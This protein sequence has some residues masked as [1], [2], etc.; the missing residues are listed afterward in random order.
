[1]SAPLP[2]IRKII[3]VDMDA[4]FAS[5]EQRDFPELQG[6]PVA[7]GGSKDRGVVAAASYEARKFGVKSAMSSRIAAKKCPDLIFQPARFDAYKEVSNQIHE[8]FKEYTDLIEPLSL[9]EAYLD[10]TE[11]KKGIK[12]ATVIANEI[13][14]SIFEKTGLTASAGISS[15]KFVAKIASDINKP[16]GYCLVH[17][18]DIESFIESLPISKF[19]GI[20]KV[21][22]KKLNSLGII[23]GKDLKRLSV[24]FLMQ[25]YG[26]KGKHYYNISRGIDHR[27]VNPNRIRKSIGAENTFES[28]LYLD[29]D[30]KKKVKGI[31]ERVHARLEKSGKKAKS[32]TLKIKF[33]DFTQ[34]TRSYT[35]PPSSPFPFYETKDQILKQSLL[36]LSQMEI[37]KS[38]VRLM[39][40]SLSNF[41]DESKIISK[42]LTIEF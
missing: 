17:P 34:I 41:N 4:F 18:K 21:T 42:Q 7:V 3:H 16:N 25:N 14:A 20:G 40:I 13:R 28:D 15:N 29:K 27:I 31:T 32:L 5:V 30:L 9:D 35:L 19:H 38:G 2:A 1:M 33:A 10:V 24:E 11:N 36:L 8:I 6:L 26:K 23:I 37:P 39:G 22:G 12:S